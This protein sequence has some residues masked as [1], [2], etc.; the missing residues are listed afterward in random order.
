[1]AKYLRHK[2]PIEKITVGGQ[3]AYVPEKWE[4]IFYYRKTFPT[5]T[6]E[7]EEYANEVADQLR[8]MRH[9]VFQAYFE[10]K[11]GSIRVMLWDGWS[12]DMVVA[13]EFASR[14]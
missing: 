12:S 2:K 5:N 6:I 13:E 7:E 4:G 8:S 9:R 10:S 3:T 14:K 1:M 11:T